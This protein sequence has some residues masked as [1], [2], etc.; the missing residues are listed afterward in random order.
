MR[1]KVREW[2]RKYQNLYKE[3]EAEFEKKKDLSNTKKNELFNLNNK[4]IEL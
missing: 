2:E 3:L 1:N 4:Y